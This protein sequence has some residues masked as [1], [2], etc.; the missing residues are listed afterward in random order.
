MK[1][2]CHCCGESLRGFTKT[3]D[4]EG[5][6]YHLTCVEDTR[7]IF[8]SLD[9]YINCCRDEQTKSLYRQTKRVLLYKLNKKL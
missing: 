9:L 3:F 1:N 4:W 6:K 8:K 2:K 5:R 7:P